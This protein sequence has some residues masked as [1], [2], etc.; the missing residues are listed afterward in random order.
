MIRIDFGTL[1]EFEREDTGRKEENRRKLADFLELCDKHD[2]TVVEQR[3]WN[4]RDLI[5]YVAISDTIVITMTVSDKYLGIQTSQIR[6]KF[7]T[8]RAEYVSVPDRLA[9]SVESPPV[10]KLDLHEIVMCNS[11][12]RSTPYD[13]YFQHCVHCGEQMDTI[14]KVCQRCDKGV[15][16]HPSFSYCPVCGDQLKQDIVGSPPLNELDPNGLVWG[17]PS[18]EED[19]DSLPP[20]GPG[21][22]ANPGPSP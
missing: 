20:P 7:N 15:L 13:G 5:H 10:E 8:Y 21:S 4:T 22:G 19:E 9:V 6:E 14:V 18:R 1:Y 2:A 11:C 16:Y 17:I 12:G 3:D